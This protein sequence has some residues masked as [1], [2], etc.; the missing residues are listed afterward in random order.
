MDHKGAWNLREWMEC[1]SG[2]EFEEIH[3]TSC[4]NKSIWNKKDLR[5]L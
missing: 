1:E 2:I 4:P 5:D 3:T